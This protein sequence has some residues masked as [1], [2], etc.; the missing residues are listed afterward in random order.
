MPRTPGRFLGSIA[1]DMDDSYERVFRERPHHLSTRH[2]SPDAEA[3]GKQAQL[4]HQKK[5]KRAMQ[6]REHAKLRTVSKAWE[7]YPPCDVGRKARLRATPSTGTPGVE[8]LESNDWRNLN[9]NSPSCSALEKLANFKAEKKEIR[10]MHRSRGGPECND[11]NRFRPS[12]MQIAKPR[13]KPG[14]GLPT[15]AVPI[16]SLK[17][18]AQKEQEDRLR[19][20]RLEAAVRRNPL[21]RQLEGGE[22]PDW[23]EVKQ[24]LREVKKVSKAI[25][26]GSK[27]L[28]KMKMDRDLF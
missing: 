1:L 18:R 7:Q 5:Q 22:E 6:K 2:V 25:K 10:M 13:R 17:L 16:S 4:L 20:K 19:K 12:W 23:S 9:G 11:P 28:K 21:S 14:E 8:V 26:G 3:Y 15:T 27:L 24:L